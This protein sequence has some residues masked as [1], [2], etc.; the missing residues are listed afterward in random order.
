MKSFNSSARS[1]ALYIPINDVRY[2]YHRSASA[3]LA[4]TSV[5]QSYDAFANVIVDVNTG[6]V[7]D[8][9]SPNWYYQSS[10][11]HHT[12]SIGNIFAICEKE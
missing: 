11:S 9:F 6:K 10:A 3:S 7:I 4:P 1:L 2:S 5:H 8:L 12:R